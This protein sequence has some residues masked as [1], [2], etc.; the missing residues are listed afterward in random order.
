[1]KK[2]D[3]VKLEKIVRNTLI[4]LTIISLLINALQFT[5][6][7]YNNMNTEKL[8]DVL[9]HPIFTFI[10]WADNI[11]L[12]IFACWYMVLAEKSKKEVVTKISFSILAM[13]T[14]ISTSVIVVNIVAE[15]FGLF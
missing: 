15:L 4:I 3:R 2:I 11:L 7:I 12:Y 14:T 10:L 9:V 8:N 1:M 13:L 6:L 5:Y